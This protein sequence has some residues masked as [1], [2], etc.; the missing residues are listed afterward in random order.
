VNQNLKRQLALRINDSVPSTSR[1]VYSQLPVQNVQN[2]HEPHTT[3]GG[4]KRHCSQQLTKMPKTSGWQAQEIIRINLN[5][6]NTL[7][8]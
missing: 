5:F 1:L 6:S 7:P 8:K 3:P 4:R 2:A